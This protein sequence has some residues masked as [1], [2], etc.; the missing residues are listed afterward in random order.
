MRYAFAVIE[1]GTISG[2]RGR[3]VLVA[4]ILVWLA[5]L[6]VW[7]AAQRPFWHD[8]VYTVLLS[9]LSL[10][11]IWRASLDGVDLM[12]PLNSIVTKG[13]HA[14]TGV[15]PVV[16][17]FTAIAGFLTACGVMFML[18]RR[19]TN[20]LIAVAAV[21]GLTLTEAWRYAIEARAYGLTLA[22]FAIALYA[23]SEAA[24]G[25]HPIRNWTVMSA[26]LALAVWAHYYAV[27]SALP[28]VCGEVVRQI[29]NRR[30][31]WAP[32]IA[33]AASGAA[34]LPLTP[35]VLAASSQRTTFWARPRT[36]EIG[37]IYEFLQNG[38]RIPTL[39]LAILGI[40]ITIELIRRAVR[41]EWPRRLPAHEAAAW[42]A[43]LAVPAAAVLIGQYVGAFARRSAILGTVGLAT[44]IPLLIWSL[45][46][47]NRLAD[48]T[49]FVTVLVAF[50]QLSVRVIA[51]PVPWTNPYADRPIISDWLQG[52]DPIVLTG[53]IDYLPMWYY[54]P[55]EARSRVLYLADPAGQQRETGTDTSDRGYL[56][57][58]RWTG[59]PV[60]PLE[61][62]LDAHR[63]FWLYSFGADWIERGL[64]RRRVTMIERAR[65]PNGS[66][67][68][69]EVI[70]AEK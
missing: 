50:G 27:L 59:V 51:D 31:H 38:L 52:Q 58:G 3:R 47:R 70:V 57:L 30:W 68:L 46:P 20:L 53:G 48:L 35:L 24:D 12:P 1:A 2:V 65:E 15:G 8:E 7:S 44:A 17:R 6:L 11:D 16:T 69:Y 21:L 26:A 4:A 40:L 18:V 36:I 42:I 5:A 39:A 61:P 37:G 34:A 66:G 33:L 41:R 9:Q 19:R 67:R 10:T 64:R 14:V 23:W 60:Q 43:C 54:A 25:R 62:F 22:F 28:I 56:A 49:V 13:V 63:R 55:V 45:G 32:W 29:R